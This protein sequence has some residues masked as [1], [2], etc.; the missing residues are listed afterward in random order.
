MATKKQGL[1]VTRKT[2]R[3]AKTENKYKNALKNGETKDLLTIEPL[4][5]FEHFR[6]IP[7]KYPHDKIAKTHHLLIPK[8]RIDSWTKF[9]RKE[10]KEF[11][12]LDGFLRH[13]YDSISQNYPSLLSVRD[14]VHWHLYILK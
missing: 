6:I 1:D 3:L 10:R 5:E 12:K 14:I 11:K 4:I 9:N 8:R 13:K 7:N 2:L